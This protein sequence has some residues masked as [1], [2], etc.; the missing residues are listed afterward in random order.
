MV[1]TLCRTKT[2]ERASTEM[3]LDVL[4]YNPRRVMT[5]PGTGV[6]MLAMRGRGT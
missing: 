2:V 6:L 3:S 4:A 5:I 1:A